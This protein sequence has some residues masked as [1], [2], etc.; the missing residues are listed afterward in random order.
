M[1]LN[2]TRIPPGRRGNPNLITTKYVKLQYDLLGK[3]LR[4]RLLSEGDDRSL[5]C[6]H[7][8]LCFRCTLQ[9]LSAASASSLSAAQLWVSTVTGQLI[10]AVLRLSEAA[11]GSCRA[12]DSVHAHPGLWPHLG[13]HAY[14]QW[15]TYARRNVLTRMY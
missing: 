13:A 15:H 12:H 1:S 11:A 3:S 8:C 9:P 5:G 2:S 6:V 14:T 7:Q 10:R 4:W